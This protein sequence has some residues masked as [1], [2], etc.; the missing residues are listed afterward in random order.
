MNLYSDFETLDH[1]LKL[2]HNDFERNQAT[3]EIKMHVEAAARELSLE[4]F[5]NFENELFQKLFSYLSGNNIEDKIG[6]IC[7]IKELTDC[8]SAAAEDKISKFA[9]VLANVLKLN[10]EPT[11][12]VLI[13]ETLGHMAKFSPISHVEFVE[14]E[15]IRA[16]EWLKSDQSHRK[17]ASTCVLQQLA[18]NAPTIF[19]T[20]TKEFFEGIWTPLW[21]N[22]EMIRVSAAQALSS[23]LIVLKQR[24]YHLEWYCHI[25]SHIH[26]GLRKGSYNC[27][28]FSL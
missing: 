14:S 21:D 22:K 7:A 24:T 18:E 23:C 19:F 27:V 25:Y 10:T 2:L 6:S 26:E 17:F 16:L 4:R 28:F 15:L 1:N 12:I 3:L 9:N 13:A 11:L 8:T 5:G 20:R